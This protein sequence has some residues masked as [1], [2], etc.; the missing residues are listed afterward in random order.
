[1][2]FTLDFEP[3]GRRGECPSGCTI[4][5]CA[6]SLGINIVNVCGGGR[7]CGS[8]VVQVINGEVSPIA[9]AEREHLDNNEFARGFRLACCAHPESDC[10]IKIPQKSL[11]TPQRTQ[12]E[13]QEIIIQPDPLTRTLF[14][15]LSPPTIDDLRSDADRLSDR[16]VADFDLET[17]RFD[18]A[19][20]KELPTILREYDWRVN[21]IIRNEEVV[22]LFPAE[23]TP[24]GIAVDLG[25]TKIAVYL[26]DLESGETL[27]ST[28]LMNPQIAYGED[29]ITRL[30]AAQKDP[31]S[32]HKFQKIIVEAI[33]EATAVLCQ[34]AEKLPC[35]IVEFVIVGNT[36]MHHL[37]LGLPV[38]QLGRA[39][40]VPAVSSAIDIKAREIGLHGSAGAYLH[41]LPN[42]AGF[43]G[44]DHVAMLLAVEIH[45]KQ[46]VVLAVDIGTNTEICL[47]NRGIFTSLSTASGPAF[48]GA[49]IKHGMRAAAGAI[50][51]FQ[52]IN[53]NHEY[54]T[55]EDSPAVGLCGSGILDVIAQLRKSG[56]INRRGK[57][58]DHSLVRGDGKNKEYLLVSPNDQ[59]S[60]N[61]EVTITQKDIKEIQ[62]AKGAIRTGINV[63]LKENNLTMNDLDQVIIA[64]AFGTY[65]DVNS[66]VEIGML[67]DIP[68]ESI[69][70]VGNA[71]GMGAKLVLISA[72]QREEARVLANQI[73][74]IE[75]AGDPDFMK[76]FAKAMYLD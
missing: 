61:A 57:I 53:G 63:L 37:I 27:R 42:I 36:A 45:K 16:L 70:Q 41:S 46:G 30:L 13:G 28:G 24:L 75:L 55:I 21:V 76:I 31:E 23:A 50:E 56:I 18:Y 2:T 3:I 54:Q 38:K 59:N 51:R 11:T 7:S 6:H 12:I 26:I 68:R 49:H 66:A 4:L 60:E 52:I 74:Y 71:A 8:C 33:N 35:H 72:K 67:P 69:L 20:L 62:L 9:D 14:V 40:Y 48:E 64:G 25:T 19:A 58:L 17:V 43:V 47:A 34:K 22:A 44:A 5:E 29:V 1:M 32:S 15:E 65:L 10:K 39:P 73:N